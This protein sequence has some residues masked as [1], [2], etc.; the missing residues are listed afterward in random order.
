MMAHSTKR[1]P[2]AAPMPIPTFAPAESGLEDD[3]DVDVSNEPVGWLEE[4]LVVVM[5]VRHVR[6][7][8]LRRNA[9]S[10]NAKNRDVGLIEPFPRSGEKVRA[11]NRRSQPDFALAI[12][13]ESNPVK[14]CQSSLSEFEIASNHSG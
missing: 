9:K 4:E 10:S 6:D 14:L 5:L 7:E 8:L 2:I 11:R 3:R 12:F 13:V 1:P